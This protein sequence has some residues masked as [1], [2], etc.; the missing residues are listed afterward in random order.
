MKTFVSSL[1]SLFVAL[2]VLLC[3]L[4]ANTT[5]LYARAGGGGGGHSSGG[6]SSSSHSS[7]SHSSSSHSSGSH[8]SSSRSSSSSGE[9]AIPG[10]IILLVLAAII[11]V[12]IYIRYRMRNAESTGLNFPDILPK[13]FAALNGAQEFL[14]ANPDFNEEEFLA[15]VEKA[16]VE[17]QTA[18]GNG[19]IRPVRRFLS[20]GV[21]QRFNT[22][23]A[24]MGLLQ[25]RDEISNLSVLSRFI[26]CVE[27][28]GL[29]DILHVAVTAG[30]RDIFVCDTNHDLDSPGGYETFTEYWT[31]LRKRGQGGKDIYFTQNCPNCSAPLPPDM[32]DAG[33]CPYCKSF[34]N[35]GEY[36]WV[37]SE[38]TQVDDYA[39]GG[40]RTSK[41]VAL[42]AQTHHLLAHDPSFCIQLIEDKASNGYLQIQTAIVF[43]EPERMRRFVSDTVFERIVAAFPPQN[44]V[45]NRLYLND[46]SVIAAAEEENKNILYVAVKSSYQRAVLE[47]DGSQLLD[48]VIMTRREI[49]LMERNKDAAVAKGSIYAHL[50]PACGAPV[51]DS[52]DVKCGYCGST[53]NSPKSEWIISGLLSPAEY[54]SQERQHPQAA[55]GASDLGDELYSV[56]DFA[57]NNALVIMS[58]DGNFAGVEIAMVNALARKWKYPAPTVKQMI[59][60]AKTGR[61]SIRMPLDPDKRSKIFALM[62][63]AAAADGAVRPEEEIVLQK[64]RQEYSV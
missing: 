8:S 48:P 59:Q 64:V 19:D 28:D 58:A 56:R 22:Q 50:C 54:A 15:K 49:L 63:K 4:L 41:N 24:M 20:D 30:M 26:D 29:Y 6:H 31:F 11:V 13:D 53:L 38:I 16:F 32:G 52:L 35:S 17:V 44:I 3:I 34:V 2:C 47:Q 9:V 14:A 42:D 60:A 27:Q 25:Q 18:W 46:V 7:S 1:K 10:Y 62:E 39:I 23:I 43:K 55:G 61:L 5:L 45:F 21:Y 37:L 51:A 57:F 36:D 12:I 33:S 40:Y